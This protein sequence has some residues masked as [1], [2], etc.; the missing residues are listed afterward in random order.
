MLV[1]QDLSA[2]RFPHLRYCIGAGEPLNPETI[3]SWQAATG[4]VIRDG[5]WSDGNG[6]AL[7]LIPMYRAEIWFHG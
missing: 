6:S 3:E 1:R 5:I 4:L 2:Y 7:R